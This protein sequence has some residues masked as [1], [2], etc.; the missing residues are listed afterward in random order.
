MNIPKL[1]QASKLKPTT[2]ESQDIDYKDRC[3]RI[4]FHIREATIIN[5]ALQSEI[6]ELQNKIEFEKRLS[7]DIKNR[8]ESL[9]SS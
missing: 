5:K 6:K 9:E 2:V 1:Q 3:E 4:E 8:I 7:K